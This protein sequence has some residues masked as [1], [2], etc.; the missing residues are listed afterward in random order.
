VLVHTGAVR[1]AVSILLFSA[2]LAADEG[3][4]THSVA[5]SPDLRTVV[6]GRMH[7]ERGTALLRIEDAAT[8]K[9]RR[10]I[11]V[12][13]PIR[14]FAFRG[15]GTRFVASNDHG[16]MRIYDTATGKALLQLAGHRSWVNHV[17]FAANR[18]ASTGRDDTLRV[19]DAVK[20]KQLWLKPKMRVGALALSPD[21]K[22][23]A[24]TDQF[25]RVQL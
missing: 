8:L 25:G 19:W 2:A 20:G 7:A 1:R 22:R 11:S 16:P 14:A 10:E 24:T 3:W 17:A 21:G 6:R 18:I 23:L 5:L 12:Q 4:V 15:D 13:G 9:S